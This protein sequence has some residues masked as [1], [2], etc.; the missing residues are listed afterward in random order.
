M[1]SKKTLVLF[2]ILC[3]LTVL[4]VIGSVLFSIKNVVGYC[5]NAEDSELNAKISSASVNGISVGSNI[6]VLNEKKII[7]NI[8]SEVANVK[9]INIERKFPSS[10]YINYIK[11]E[12]YFEV[13]VSG[14]HLYVSNDCKILSS[15]YS[16]S[17]QKYISLLFNGKPDSTKEGNRLFA[18]TSDLYSIVN[19]T[20]LTLSRLE[21]YANII[22]IFDVVDLRFVDVNLLYLKTSAGVSIEI[23]NPKDDLL[24]KIQW[25]MTYLN[26]A[27]FDHKSKGT[28][29]VA[30]AQNALQASYSEIDRYGERLK[31]L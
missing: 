6:F 20:M 31:E 12:A 10:V 8:E 16:P 13:N 23:Q 19:E 18:S 29:I 21:K 11:I 30:S 22:E 2:L 5:Y 27:D 24:T 4:I 1:K 7:D 3:F 28:I 9:V 17:S 25:A 15:S 26:G 14:E